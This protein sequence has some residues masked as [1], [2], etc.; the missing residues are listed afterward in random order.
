MFAYRLSVIV[1]LVLAVV[2]LV[3][4]S[5]NAQSDSSY[6]QLGT[7]MSV[8]VPQRYCGRRLS[9]ILQTVCT[10]VYNN[11]FKKNVQQ[12]DSKIQRSIEA[13][14]RRS[15]MFSGLEMSDYPINYERP[16]LFMTGMG[17]TQ[18]INRYHGSRVRRQRGIYEECCLNGCTVQELTT[19]C[20]PSQ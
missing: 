8:E 18:F 20:G 5:G 13:G 14:T 3:P 15:N 19:Y 9:N 6:H 1:T 7:R 17:A 2:F 4:E 12:E 11:M 16:S 10:G